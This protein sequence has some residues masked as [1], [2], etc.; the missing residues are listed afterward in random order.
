MRWKLA[1]KLLSRKSM[2][3]ESHKYI[4][5][6]QAKK[7][8]EL[9]NRP[10]EFV[11]ENCWKIWFSYVNHFKWGCDDR[12]PIPKGEILSDGFDGQPEIMANILEF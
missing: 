11:E 3:L 12:K 10:I 2:R 7:Y 4:K 8:A 9:I 5:R 1:K 6:H